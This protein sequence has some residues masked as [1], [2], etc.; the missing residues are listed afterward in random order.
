LCCRKLSSFCLYPAREEVGGINQLGAVYEG[1]LSYTGFFA[2]EKLYEVKPADVKATDE[3]QQSYFVPESE[4]GKYVEEEFV[5][6]EV[7]DGTPGQM[8]RKTYERGSFIFRL[9]GRDREKSAS[10]YTP[11]CLTQCVVKYSL[12]ELLKDKS[13][14][15]ILKLRICEPAMG[16]AA[17][18]NEAVNQL[19]DA[20]LERKQ[21]ELGEQVPPS[22]YPHERQKVKAYL[23]THNCHGVDLNPVAVE[24]ARISLWLN[25]IHRGSKCPW[26]GLRLAVGNSLIGCRRQVFNA[27]DLRT[28]SS[29]SNWLSMVP[30]HVALGPEWKDRPKNSVYHFLVPDSGMAKFDSD[31][32]IKELAPDDVKRIKEWRKDFCKPFDQYDTDRLIGL[33]DSIDELWKQVIRERREAIKKTNKPV[34][35]W[36]QPPVPPNPLMFQ[37]QDKVAAELERPYTAYRRLKLIM[38]YWCALWFWP[39]EQSKL[40]PTRDVFLLDIEMILKG[41]ITGKSTGNLMLGL[42]PSESLSEEH[43]I[44]VERFGRVNVDDL[45][46]DEKV[47]RYGVA[48]GVARSVRFHHWEL[49]FAEVFA[50][51]GGFDLILGNPPWVKIEWNEGGILSDFQPLL[52]LRDMSASDIAKERQIHLKAQ[53]NLAAYLGE[54]TGQTGTKAF[55]NAVQN[56]PLLLKVQTNLYKCFITRA[57]EIGSTTGIASFLHPEGV[58]DD[59]KGGALR[60]ASYL[61]LGNHFQFI[62]ELILFADVHHLTK[63]SV[64]VYRTAS[65]QAVEFQQ[66]SNL[67]HPVTIEG[68]Q[69]HDGHGIVPGYKNDENHWELRPHR[70]RIVYVNQDR[71]SLFAKLYDEPGTPPLQARLPIIHSAEI[72]SVLEKFA[73]QPRR[74]GDLEGEYFSLEMWHETSAQKDGTIRRETRY[75]K[76]ASEWILSGPHFFVGTPFNK[77]PNEGCSTNLDYSKIDLTAIPAD[78]LPRTN[79]VPACSPEE[80]LRRTPKWN[81]KPVTEFYRHVHR[82]MVGPTAERTLIPAILPPAVGHVNTVF[83]LTFKQDGHLLLYNALASSLVYDFFIKTTGMGHVNANLAAALPMPDISTDLFALMSNRLLRLTCLTGLYASLWNSLESTPWTPSSALRTD[84]D[85][86]RVLVELDALAALALELTEEELATIYR[87]QFPVLQQYEREDRYDRQGRQV[88]G[89]VL[90]MAQRH[91]IDIHAPLNVHTFRGDASLVG[92]VETPEL[93]MTGGIRWLDPKMEPRMERIY[94]PPY[95]KNDREAEMRQAYRHFQEKLCNG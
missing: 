89:E 60:E 84:W 25:T 70:S 93:G 58:Y 83:C 68:S 12:K 43:R 71:L 30:E 79:Y 13:A 53:G 55:L 28:K 73:E 88:P 49:R 22:D 41:T 75:P 87:V 67:F 32:V 77:T 54:F 57:W 95:T 19:A 51:N 24:L 20:Y 42:D 31:K 9:A 47:P 8:R 16:S 3:T 23:A 14:D 61:R 33:S 7:E 37:E 91:N 46:R 39:I 80:Y 15:D 48:D 35:V 10:Y 59:P 17:F 21:K 26:F 18:I 85:R 1:L 56:Y 29:K 65:R 40:L 72:V 76:D 50:D 5:M 62:N 45:C 86:R 94:P 44:F 66:V 78:Y 36:G 4:I 74:L 64:N 52:A 38:D 34:D 82:E 2:Q 6:E 90:K 81:G 63:Y 69:T 27:E 92:E 11:E